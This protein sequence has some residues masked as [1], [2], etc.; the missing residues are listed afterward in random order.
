MTNSAAVETYIEPL[1]DRQNTVDLH[2]PSKIH[3]FRTHAN[4]DI[5]YNQGNH[6]QL[7]Y[8]WKLV[9]DLDDFAYGEYFKH[10]MNCEAISIAQLAERTGTDAA[11]YPDAVSA[12][13]YRTDDTDGYIEVQKAGYYCLVGNEDCFSTNLHEVSEFLRANWL[14]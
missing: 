3:F 2:N 6:W 13:F 7:Y 10:P 5:Y 1:P 9:D 12:L 11:D 14:E 8:N 4:G